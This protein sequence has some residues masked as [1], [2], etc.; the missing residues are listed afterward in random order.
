MVFIANDYLPILINLR[1]KMSSMESIHGPPFF[2]F[3]KRI[4]KLLKFLQ[5]PPKI[6]NFLGT[7]NLSLGDRTQRTSNLEAA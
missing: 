7:N 1:Y 6:T 3:P 4:E 5:Q 2:Q